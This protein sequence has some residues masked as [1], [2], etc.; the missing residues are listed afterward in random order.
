MISLHTGEFNI[1]FWVVDLVWAGL[2]IDHPCFQPSFPWQTLHSSPGLPALL[3][4]SLL[5]FQ[6][7]HCWFLLGS[8]FFPWFLCSLG[9]EGKL[10]AECCRLMSLGSL[11]ISPLLAASSA[12]LCLC[13]TAGLQES[14]AG[15]SVVC[16]PLLWEPQFLEGD[17]KGL[18]DS[19]GG[20]PFPLGC[21]PPPPVC[22]RCFLM[23]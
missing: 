19:Q 11:Y 18:W 8:W 10:Q 9:V 21:Q 3:L 17:R 12:S 1:L 13:S 15:R 6:P 2:F 5:R 4:K 7:L 22:L 23:P 16:C 20:L 14:P